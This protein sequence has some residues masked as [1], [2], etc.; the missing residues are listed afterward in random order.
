LFHHISNV[1]FEEIDPRREAAEKASRSDYIKI[2]RSGLTR[3]AKLAN[4]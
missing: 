3:K 2:K 1:L 4:A